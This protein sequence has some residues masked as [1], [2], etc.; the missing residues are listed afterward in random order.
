LKADAEASLT[1]T[2]FMTEAQI[3]VSG[4]TGWDAF[5]QLMQSMG[6]EADAEAPQSE[7]D[8][9][10][11]LKLFQDAQEC[12]STQ[13]EE[14][15]RLQERLDELESTADGWLDGQGKAPTRFALANARL[16][17]RTLLE[18]GAPG[19]RLYPQEDGGV[20]A[21]W[22]LPEHELSISFGKDQGA[23]IHS[24]D[25]SADR[26]QHYYSSRKDPIEAA[27]MLLGLGLQDVADDTPELLRRWE[28]E[29]SR[30]GAAAAAQKS[31]AYRELLRR[32][33]EEVLREA[34]TLLVVEPSMTLLVLLDDIAGEHPAEKTLGLLPAAHAWMQWGREQG[35][36]EIQISR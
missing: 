27:R 30:F 7:A 32:P 15:S 2:G 16:A 1:Y 28:Q 3:G 12:L 31:S 17:L 33:R 21:E 4:Y 23:Y 26:T 18:A 5:S 8:Q 35:L 24:V 29:N 19:G 36:L 6:K 14:L 10:K 11:V 9:Q 13:T 34:L 22:S 20:Q 25:T